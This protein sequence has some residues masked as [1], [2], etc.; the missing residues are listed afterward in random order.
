MNEEFGILKQMIPA[1]RDQE[2]HKLAIL[3]ASIEY[4]RYLEQCVSDLE[5]NA[6]APH[7]AH[8]ALR[9]QPLPSNLAAAEEDAHQMED[10][11]LAKLRPRKDNRHGQW[12]PDSQSVSPAL[13]GQS[14][15][16]PSAT[17]SVVTPTFP[18]RTYSVSSYNS[19]STSP[20]TAP[21]PTGDRDI[22]HEV[23]EA[24]LMLNSG[25]RGSSVHGMSVKD[26]L[27]A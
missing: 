3:Q 24:L 6:V 26:L 23:S 18:P 4:M 5:A 22:D 7:D 27:T 15:S 1:C 19:L 13:E 20:L 16:I 14:N 8:Y 9:G 25:R 21:Q 11:P 12:I 2:M 10:M 17:S